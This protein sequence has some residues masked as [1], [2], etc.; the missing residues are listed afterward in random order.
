[1]SRRGMVWRLSCMIGEGCG[2]AVIVIVVVVVIV[3]AVE[4]VVIVV[5]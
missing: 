5:M 4:A 3:E 2:V 1:M